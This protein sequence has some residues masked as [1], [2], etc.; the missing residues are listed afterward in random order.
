MKKS[1]KISLLCGALLTAGVYFSCGGSGGGS[2][3][4]FDLF[5]TA[6]KAS[7]VVK[8]SSTASVSSAN[9]TMG[10][11]LF[12]IYQLIQE[13]N[14]E[15]DNGVI[16]GSNMHKALY[17]ANN[18]VT[19]ALRG[20]LEDG[21]HGITEQSIT[22]PFDFGTDSLTQTYNCAYTTTET[23]TPKS[24]GETNYI[25]S[26]AVKYSGGVYD[27]LMGWYAS[28]ATQD[29][30]SA[31]QLQYNTIT[32]DIIVNNAYFVNYT[33]GSMAPGSYNVRIYIN[34]NT[35][36]H[37]FS[38]KLLKAGGN[39][40]SIAGYGYSEGA[41]KYYLFKVIDMNDSTGKYFCIP[42]NATEDTLRA[43]EDAGDPGYLTN[44]ADLVA[45]LPTNYKTDGSDSATAASKFTGAGTSGIEL[46][47]TK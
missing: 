42:S 43:M 23:G 11:T 39:N 35:E 10:H 33:S 13:Y 47:W 25:K 26:Y 28:S 38:L 5:T 31:T 19:D 44:C 27:M 34:G 22:S 14:N 30:P 32:N 41:N 1:I 6:E 12:E 9:W 24:G 37:L 45:G 17:E 40:P 4:S 8:P 2:G 36:T 3:S 29:S 15:T 16:D 18:Y 21:T 20:C 46:T 7:P